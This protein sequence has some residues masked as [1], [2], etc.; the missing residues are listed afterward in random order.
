M[1]EENRRLEEK[2]KAMHFQYSEANNEYAN[3]LE[4]RKQMIE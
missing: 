4:Q 2:C 1:K 3:K